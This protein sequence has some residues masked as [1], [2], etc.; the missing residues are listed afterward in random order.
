M[1]SNSID[2]HGF[3]RQ[4]AV[5]SSVRKGIIVPSVA[6]A[7]EERKEDE[8]R[9]RSRMAELL[10]KWPFGWDKRTPPCQLHV[11]SSTLQTLQRLDCALNKASINIIERWFD[12]HEADFSQRMPLAPHEERALKVS[13]QYRSPNQK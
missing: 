13:S 5:L 6:S 9:V 3:T 11:P 1:A 10:E 12:D 7:L 2:E 8:I 4:F